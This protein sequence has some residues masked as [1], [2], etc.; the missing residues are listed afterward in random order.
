M[1]T[2]SYLEFDIPPSPEVDATDG[3]DRDALF[4]GQPTILRGLVKE[5]PCVAAAQESADA[6]ARYLAKLDNGKPLSGFDIDPEQGGRYFYN[7][8][9]DGFNFTSRKTTI[10]EALAY[11]LEL[12]EQTDPPGF[13]VGASPSDDITPGFAAENPLAIADPSARPLLW[14]GNS[15]RIAPHFD[16][17]D[18]I[19]CVVSGARTFLTFPPEEMANLYVGPIHITVAGPPTSMIDPRAFDPEEFPKF[20]AALASARIAHLEPGDAIVIPSMWWHYVEASGPLNLLV[21]YWTPNRADQ[22][23]LNAVMLAILLM[24]DVPQRQ[25]DA[26]SALFQHYVFGEDAEHAGAHLP[27]HAK[28]PLAP[29]SKPRD[30]MIKAHLRTRLGQLLR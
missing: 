10:S 6:L 1:P 17:S 3:V 19:A 13:Y 22:Q 21:N 20:E 24:R 27:A 9:I 12:K 30:M 29:V 28:G 26:T 18:N 4:E 15:S 23:L 8:A 7:K 5:W 14:L 16:V 2:N 25:R 11:L